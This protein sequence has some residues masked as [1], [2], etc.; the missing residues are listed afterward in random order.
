MWRPHENK[1][2]SSWHSWGYH[3]ALPEALGIAV[4]RRDWAVSSGAGSLLLLFAW[5]AIIT[6]RDLCLKVQGPPLLR[7][8][9]PLTTW[10]QKRVISLFSIPLL[11]LATGNLAPLDAAA[12]FLCIPAPG[13]ADAGSNCAS[14]IYSMPSGLCSLPSVL[15]TNKALE[16]SQK[17]HF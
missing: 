5:R 3:G 1:G 15:K 6:V 12:S 8:C 4:S 2:Q 7:C 11:P 16:V 17:P 9:N 10:E 13:A 14:C